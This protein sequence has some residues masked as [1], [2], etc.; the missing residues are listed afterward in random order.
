MHLVPAVKLRSRDSLAVEVV[1]GLQYVAVAGTREVTVAR[2][3]LVPI[4]D[5]GSVVVPEAV[6][7]HA[8]TSLSAVKDPQGEEELA[9]QVVELG[10]GEVPGARQVILV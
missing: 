2:G 9:N 6:P 5:K 4:L 1:V 8:P 10:K 3:L 7:P